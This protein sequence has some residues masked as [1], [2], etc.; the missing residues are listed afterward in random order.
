MKLY[1]YI[2]AHDTGRAPCVDSGRVTLATCKPLIRRGARIGD[3]V[4]G[5]MPRPHER[6]ELV[7]AGRVA[8]IVDWSDYSKRCSDRIDAVYSVADGGRV[9]RLDPA[10][11][12]DA[13]AQEKDLSGPILLF[14]EDCTWYFGGSPV[15]LPWELQH[16]AAAGRGHRISGATVEDIKALEQWLRDGSQPGVHDVPRKPDQRFLAPAP[17]RIGQRRSL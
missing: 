2:L 9:E 14:D 4:A 10:Y 13:N 5:F 12:D 17:E 3:W 7:Y 11:H 6:G 16:L 8:E 15:S 1:R